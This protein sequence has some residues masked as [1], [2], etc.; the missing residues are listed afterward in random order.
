MVEPRRVVHSR[1]CHHC[2]GTGFVLLVDE[3]GPGL[4]GEDNRLCFDWPAERCEACRQATAAA[5]AQA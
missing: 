4:H 3:G 5:D 2:D 1:N